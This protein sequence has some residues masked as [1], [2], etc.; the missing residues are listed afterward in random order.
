M[1]DEK[2]NDEEKYYYHGST[3]TKSAAAATSIRPTYS[4]YKNKY[5]TSVKKSDIINGLTR[6]PKN[7]E[8]NTQS[9]ESNSLDLSKKKYKYVIR[10]TYTKQRDQ[11]V[12]KNEEK[13]G[14]VAKNYSIPFLHND[15]SYLDGRFFT[16]NIV[17]N[18]TPKNETPKKS[19]KGYF[20]SGTSFTPMQN[21]NN[22]LNLAHENIRYKAYN[23]GKNTKTHS[24]SNL[25]PH[26]KN[27]LE[28][29]VISNRAKNVEEEWLNTKV[30]TE[31]SREAK[32]QN[33]NLLDGKETNQTYT[34][35]FSEEISTDEHLDVSSSKVHEVRVL[36]PKGFIN[37]LKDD[38]VESRMTFNSPSSVNRLHEQKMDKNT[39]DLMKLFMD[40]TDDFE[41][42]DKEITDL[43]KRAKDI[44]GQLYKRNLKE[45]GNQLAERKP[46]LSKIILKKI[47]EAEQMSKLKMLN[48][49]DKNYSDTLTKPVQID[50]T[51]YNQIERRSGSQ[52]MNSSEQTLQPRFSSLL[53]G[54]LK[55]HQIDAHNLP[56]KS[57]DPPILRDDGFSNIFSSVPPSSNHFSKFRKP[58]SKSQPPML[59]SIPRTSFEC[60]D[61]NTDVKRTAGYYADPEADCQV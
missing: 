34:N 40:H 11:N 12:T 41:L 53:F 37:K 47:K 45:S 43:K 24:S 56:Q 17:E 5:V 22:R 48:R 2:L 35:R 51:A 23:D 60:T 38:I 32:Q 58:Q 30:G 39:V 21:N 8:V 27:T 20:A 55:G 14:H 9:S 52:I 15:K 44:E 29:R 3:S 36:P 16:K 57:F 13:T 18:T 49:Q 25:L 33:L 19:L 26:A 7:F 4:N 1:Q 59:T 31:R 54:S 61:V 10:G 50:T 6:I 28:S 42:D 46:R